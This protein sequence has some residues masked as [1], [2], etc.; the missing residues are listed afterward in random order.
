M[1]L[2]L[3]LVRGRLTA[4]RPLAPFVDSKSGT[5]L[6]GLLGLDA[7]T[8]SSRLSGKTVMLTDLPSAG[9]S[10][11]VQG[12][13]RNRGDPAAR[14]ADRER[15]AAEAK[16]RAERGVDGMRRTRQ[17]IANTGTGSTVE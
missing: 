3:D 4:Q 1:E 10:S 13:K 2:A 11:L 5:D 16:D 15:Q 7:G 12:R 17:R 8:Y 14:Q 9:P 6:P